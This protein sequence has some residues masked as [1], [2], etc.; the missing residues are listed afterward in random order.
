VWSGLNDGSIVE[1]VY[2][3]WGNMTLSHVNIPSAPAGMEFSNRLYASSSSTPPDNR[4]HDLGF[5]YDENGNLIQE[6]TQGMAPTNRPAYSYSWDSRSRMSSL[7]DS[8]ASDG[9]QRPLEEFRY[10]ESGGRVVKTR[11]DRG[12][13]TRLYLRDGS[14]RLLAEYVKSPT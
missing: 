2:D 8:A 10:D 4:V 14:G 13:D 5:A 12:G 6:A 7:N 1:N 11:W 9:Y 3:A